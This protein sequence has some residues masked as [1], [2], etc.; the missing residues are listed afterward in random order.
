M[1]IET[2]IALSENYI[3]SVWFWI[4]IANLILRLRSY[5]I[6]P[7]LLNTCVIWQM[8]S[9]LIRK[10]KIFAISERKY[11]IQS[12]SLSLL[13]I[14]QQNNRIGFNRKFLPNGIHFSLVLAFIDK[15]SGLISKIL[16]K[17]SFIFGIYGI[18]LE[19]GQ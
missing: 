18:I 9:A 14:I 15:F 8:S 13:N 1:N 19:L 7:Q 6:F 3:T 11:Y 10:V 4:I 17:T 5:K 12:L 2:N 16:H